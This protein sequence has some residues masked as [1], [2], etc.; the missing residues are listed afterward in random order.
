MSQPSLLEIV[1]TVFTELGLTAPAS[2][3]TSTDIGVK[4]LYALVNREGNELRKATDWKALDTEFNIVVTQP[5]VTTGDLTQLS[6]IVSNIPSTAGLT[7]GLWQVSASSVPVAARILSVDSATQVTM[8]MD[9]TASSTGGPVTFAKDTYASPTDF[10]HYINRTWWDRTNRWELIGP[11]SPQR[12][13]WQLSG[14]IPTGPRRHWRLIGPGQNNYRIWPPPGTL[15]TPIQLAFEYISNN[16][17]AAADGTYKSSMTAD[18]DQPVLDGQAIILG[19]KWRFWQIKQFDYMP[20][21]IEYR[22]YVD[23]LIARDGGAKTLS[24]AKRPYPLLIGPGN[25]PDG[26]WPASGASN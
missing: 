12:A 22:D 19:A 18:T 8:T 14:I 1:Q 25:V 9:A 7:A 6:P 13:E 26:N 15:D 17:V 23:R 24:L 11:D 10:D 21:Q 4:Q 3:V 16:W 20:L 5:I 2:V